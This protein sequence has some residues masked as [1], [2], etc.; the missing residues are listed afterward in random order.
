VVYVNDK[1]YEEAKD[2]AKVAKFM[3]KMR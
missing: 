1:T 3:G 2:L